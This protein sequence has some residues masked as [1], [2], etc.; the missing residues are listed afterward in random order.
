MLDY[1]NISLD[2]FYPQ[3]QKF[4]TLLTYSFIILYFLIYYRI[5]PFP[6]NKETLSSYGPNNLNIFLAFNIVGVLLGLIG[7]TPE[8]SEYYRY[9]FFN[10]K[11]DEKKLVFFRTGYLV[12][13]LFIISIA[14][15]PFIAP[16]FPVFSPYMD[17]IKIPYG[18]IYLLLATVVFLDRFI[19][20]FTISLDKRK[21]LA[22]FFILTV[23]PY[24]GNIFY[25]NERLFNFV[26]SLPI[27]YL[28]SL[29]LVFWI[30][31][32]IKRH[33]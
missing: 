25:K 28:Y 24:I 13:F 22:I 32:I 18:G 5:I 9:S 6:V 8:D 20:I 19:H 33:Q 15:F 12:I 31:K 4:I 2:R 3:Y 26:V 27:I 17:Q 16:L 1:L 23:I 14:V 10:V 21:G 29:D 11:I 7:R 30:I